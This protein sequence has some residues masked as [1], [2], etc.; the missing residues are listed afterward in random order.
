M[1]PDLSDVPDVPG[2]GPDTP[3]GG[4]MDPESTPRSRLPGNLS[5]HLV[6]LALTLL[7]LAGMYFTRPLWHLA[8]FATPAEG[9]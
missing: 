2:V 5:K 9:V 8:S 7:L 6:K 4:S 3:E 1:P